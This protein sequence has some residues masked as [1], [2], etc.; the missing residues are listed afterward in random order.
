[1]YAGYRHA[2]TPARRPMRLRR[3]RPLAVHDAP[4]R[5]HSWTEDAEWNRRQTHDLKPRR[6]S[7]DI[8][9]GDRIILGL[10]IGIGNLHEQPVMPMGRERCHIRA[11]TT[12]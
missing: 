7:S 6:F 1:M 9:D 5:L 11:A 10:S 12:R 2:D 8:H 3:I 4:Y